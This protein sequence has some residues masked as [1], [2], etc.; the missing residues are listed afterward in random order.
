L[1]FSRGEARAPESHQA[2]QFHDLI[3]PHLD[4]AYSFARYLARDATA[5]EDIVQEAFLRA[6]RAL[7]SYRGG[8]AKAW[9]FAIVRNSFLDWAA[10][11]RG[12]ASVVVEAETWRLSAIADP[13]QVSPEEALVR[14]GEI[15][16]VRATIENLPEPFRETLVLRELEELSYKEISVLTGAPIGTVM[17][18]LARARQM[19]CALLLPGGDA[20]LPETKEISR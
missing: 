4:S 16:A 12:A 14:S 5:A 19:L 13:R 2:R 3:L 17:S 10:A 18:R 11:R 1:A 6:Y 9:L 15:G 8:S 7:P 20:S